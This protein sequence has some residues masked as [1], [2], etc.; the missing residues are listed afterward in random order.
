MAD[1]ALEVPVCV[2]RGNRRSEEAVKEGRDGELV[3]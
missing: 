3:V 1:A 2:G